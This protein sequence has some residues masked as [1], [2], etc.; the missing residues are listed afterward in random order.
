MIWMYMYVETAVFAQVSPMVMCIGG[1]D[2]S[3][4]ELKYA[5]RYDSV[6]CSSV[7]PL[8]EFIDDFISRKLAVCAAKEA[9]LDTMCTIVDE[10]EFYRKQLF[11]QALFQDLV[12]EDK[13]DT[14]EGHLRD[15]RREETIHVEHIFKRIPQ[16]VPGPMLLETKALLDSIYLQ[17]RQDDPVAFG[18]YVRKFSDEPDDFWIRSL[19]TP[20]EFED[21]VWVL[22]PGMYS[23]PFFTPRGIHIVKV[24]DRKELSAL[25]DREERDLLANFWRTVL[26]GFSTGEC[27][28]KLLE[29]CRF[30]P[31]EA[32]MAE[33]FRQGKTNRELFSLSDEKFTG[34]DFARFAS[35]YPGT[36]KY[37]LDAFVL[38]TVLDY[39]FSCWEQEDTVARMRWKAYRDSLLFCAVHEREVVQKCRTDE[40]TL[41][42]YFEKHQSNYYWDK[43]RYNG[44]VLHCINRRTSRQIRKLLKQIPEDEWMD[45]I[46][47]VFNGGGEQRV[48][49]E[50]GLFIWGQNAYVDYQVFKK[51]DK[52]R[53]L[54]AFPHT[55]L[56]GV[57]QKGPGHY[58][59][60]REAVMADYQQD[61]ER[62]WLASLRARIKVEINEEVLK[63][64]NNHRR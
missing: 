61:L 52:P 60:V 58:E 2:V 24:L 10:V 47:L 9:G 35:I 36:L 59:E 20:K 48:C 3:L 45:A 6:Q 55:S 38:K 44:I 56:Y 23:S 25:D 18:R 46:R 7:R 63:T 30:V 50:Q 62:R 41:Q 37:Q 54:S 57:L 40:K 17:L 5:Y 22:Q 12:G 1:E 39:Q 32:G 64:V 51:G 53:P 26:G 19:Q 43:P 13:T 4:V 15:K 33:L 49:A 31:H 28:E 8:D 42:K 16:N 21:S 34:E 29:V 11:M 14:R 27:W